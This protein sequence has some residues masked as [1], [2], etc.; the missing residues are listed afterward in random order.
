VSEPEE[1]ASFHLAERV[2]SVALELGIE[3]AVI[4]ALALA[5]HNY[6][7]ATMDTDLAT[8]VDVFTQ[9]KALEDRLREQGLRV[10][11]RLPDEDDPVGGVLQVWEQEDDDGDPLDRVEVV[12][13]R[14]PYRPRLTRSSG[15]PWPAS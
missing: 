8:S 7:R 10:E 6:V 9:L 15:L 14:N 11:L 5:A 13:F 2:A 4:G 3:S 1:P 12:N